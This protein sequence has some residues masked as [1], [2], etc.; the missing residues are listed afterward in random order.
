MA[1]LSWTSGLF[2]ALALPLLFQTVDLLGP[3][4]PGPHPGKQLQNHSKILK[5]LRTPGVA[6]IVMELNVS[7]SAQVCN[8]QTAHR[9][10]F[11]NSQKCTCDALDDQVGKCIKIMV[12]LKVL[13]VHCFLCVDKSDGRHHY[14]ANL[15]TRDLRTLYFVCLCS[16]ITSGQLGRILHSSMQSTIQTLRWCTYAALSTSQSTEKAIYN[17]QILP[18]LNALFHGGTSMENSLLA[19]RPISRIFTGLIREVTCPGLISAFVA[20]P[21]VLTH[22]IVHDHSLGAKILALKPAAF[23]NL[24]HIGT[25]HPFN[26]EVTVCGLPTGSV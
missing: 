13:H 9:S 6:A 10:L 1:A 3:K 19:H 11:R 5:S 18:S 7:L 16:P 4:I 8:R 20:S 22:F 2:R 12:N 15:E 17:S 25:F 23:A 24:Q 21:G 26:G 14:M